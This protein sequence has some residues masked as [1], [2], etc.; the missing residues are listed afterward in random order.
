MDAERFFVELA[1]AFVR[2]SRPDLKSDGRNLQE[3]IALGREQGLSL[4]KFKR[5]TTLPRV[6]KVLG[7][8]RGLQPSSILDIG[9]GRGV[10]LWPLLDAFPDLP[11]T[12][13]D[14]EPLRARDLRAVNAGGV[15]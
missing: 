6:R 11:V 13:L 12:A 5:S 15:R 1:G 9:S 2:G 4:H 8:L 7:I 3:L 10:F 14:L